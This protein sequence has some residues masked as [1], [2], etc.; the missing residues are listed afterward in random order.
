MIGT[1]TGRVRAWT[2][3]TVVA[4]AAVAVSTVAP[5]ASAGQLADD[6]PPGVEAAAVQESWT[7]V[8]PGGDV[9][10]TVDLDD[11]GALSYHTDRNGEQ[12]LA[13][14][15]LGVT[16]TDADLS[17]GL[18]LVGREDTVVNETYEL[19]TGKASTSRDHA[20]ESTL[21]FAGA[22][23]EELELVVRAYDD[24][25]AYRYVLPG[26]GAA[27]LTG[28][29]SEFRV[30]EG[31]T[32][33]FQSW[34]NNYE[35]FYDEL[36][37][38]DVA[39]GREFGFPIL[40][41][42]ASG[43]WMM[44]SEAAV[45]DSFA[46]S[47]A[48]AAGDGR[49]VLT[50]PEDSV[51]STLPWQTPWRLAMFGDDVADVVESTRI[52]DLNPPSQI[53]DTSWIK[54][55]RVA[56]SWWSNAGSPRDE[57]RQREFVDF[58]AEL[59][60]EYVLV[61]EG[62]SAEWVPR[63]VEYA[64]ERDVEI[65][66]WSHWTG[67]D[68]E[69]ELEKLALWKSW[70]VAGV[71][72]DFMD[73]DTQERMG[74]YQDV[75]AE[76][77]EQELLLNYHGSTAQQG[78][79]RTWPH[80]MTMEG[81]WGAEQYWGSWPASHNVDLVFTRNVTGSMDYTPVVFSTGN[82]QTTLAHELATGI[83]F[84]S[85]L[86]HLADSPESYREHA[87]ALPL[88]S[89]L[90]T[91]WDE[92]ELVGGHP[93]E[94]AAV[95]RRSGEDW[96]LGVISGTDAMRGEVALDMLGEGPYV[97]D[98]YRDGLD[99]NDGAAA[100]VATSGLVTAGTV[101]PLGLGENGGLA[102]SL[103][104]ATPEEAAELANLELAPQVILTAPTANGVFPTDGEI[105]LSAEADDV[106]GEVLRVDF[107]VD[108]E[109]VATTGTEPFTASWT[110]PSV[111][112]HTVVAAA[113][114]DE[115]NV[116]YSGPVSVW[117]EPASDS[118]CLSEE[119]SDDFTGDQLDGDRWEVV[120]EVG[121][122][123]RVEDGAL[124]IDTRAG[125]LYAGGAAD[126]IVLQDMPEGMWQA[127]TQ[128][129]ADLNAGFQQ[130][131]LVIYQGRGDYIAVNLN[132]R[133]DSERRFQFVREE[134]GSARY[135]N[136]DWFTVP[137]DFPDTY[138]VRLTSD[139]ETVTAAYSADGETFRPFGRPADLT[140]LENAG[141]GMI[142]VSGGGAQ[143]STEAAFESFAL[144]VD[145]PADT[146]PPTASAEAV[147]ERD[148]ELY[149]GPVTVTVTAQ[150]EQS[151]VEL[152]EVSVDGGE[153]TA[154]DGPV[155][156]SEPGEHNV[157]YRATDVA[158]N[159]SEAASVSFTIAAAPVEVTPAAVTFTDEDGTEDDTF[160]VPAVAG[161]EYVVDGEVVA[162]GTYPGA[163][164]VTVTAR[165][166]DGFVLAEGAQ[167]EWVHAFSTEGGEPGEPGPD[168]RT[169]Q[170][171]LS[172]TWRGSTD[173]SFMYGRWADEVFIGD[174]DGNGTDTI[175][176][177]RGNDFHVS[178]AQR[179]GDADVVLTYGRPGDVILVGDW[180]GDGKDTF[181]VRRGATYHV[182]NSLRGGEADV[183]FRY[184]RDDD[185]VL[186]GDWDGD[187]TDTL[188]VRRTA[189]YHVKNSLRG[190]DADVTFTYG[191]AGDVTLAGD[192]DGNGTDT[193]AIQ[194]G[195]IYHVNNSLRGGEA[196]TVVTFGR[197]GD[198]VHVGDWNADGTDTL[199]IRRPVGLAAATAGPGAGRTVTK[200]AGSA[201]KAS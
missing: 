126:N 193:F 100:I 198:E 7:V 132:A 41:E 89:A 150:D 14:S 93:G 145:C 46:V 137:S 182:K 177:R 91:T 196:D 1:R 5:A 30:P 10:V 195:R 161:V 51:S 201:A 98:V 83:V 107:L 109:A 13:S 143:H 156:V 112:R 54:P 199:G 163:G 12:V 167:T 134:N 102:V 58:A 151:G 179:G 59:G 152:V 108:G 78:W 35:G 42:Q 49:F 50:L 44:L 178:N 135:S 69:V 172:N 85:A 158:G 117:V 123:L 40:V 129:T 184:G 55:G 77:A 32:G 128:I 4:A 148:G 146:T 131:G 3:T 115:G 168:D 120:N 104:P 53:E 20:T 144:A 75:L 147:G 165:A 22:D 133:S 60:W 187:D 48:T 192:W 113:F 6:A 73:A 47:R 200:E 197:A 105:T 166:L 96:Y 82:R 87:A 124:R 136:D 57:A 106:D 111:G 119:A 103:R 9:V 84:E 121:E 142:A 66:L 33:W 181:A 80:L 175:A 118:M 153:W 86:Q 94:Y 140:F 169:A 127:T 16:L 139:G 95:A 62:W 70:G 191:R 154:Y 116:G 141:L 43:G 92:T 189:T 149:V 25:A 36:A 65:L 138:S 171:H 99:E 64:A 21:T 18:E 74:F 19:L 45:D 110:A 162:T 194:R 39:A 183:V 28:E 68:T 114:D 37:V 8:S 159:V 15:P 23:G 170:F 130:A 90:P 76:T 31:A 155:E 63:L 61:D 97:A 24:A 81:V 185:Q 125:D 101:L 164:T 72:I 29:A 17:T 160:T 27:E 11:A 186:V 188:A 190:G 176:V 67:L 79:S 26:E 88:L 157:S 34:R 122:D 2:A 174:W 180:D 52:F 71:K 38:S 56:W 173:L